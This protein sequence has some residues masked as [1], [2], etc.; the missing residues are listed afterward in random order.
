MKRSGFVPLLSMMAVTCSAGIG[1]TSGP[2]SPYPNS[3]VNYRKKDDC[4]WFKAEHL[5]L[6]DLDGET[7]DQEGQCHLLDNGIRDNGNKQTGI[8]EI[9]CGEGITIKGFTEKCAMTTRTSCSSECKEV[10]NKMNERKHCWSTVATLAVPKGFPFQWMCDWRTGAGMNEFTGLQCSP[11]TKSAGYMTSFGFKLKFDG[12]FKRAALA[13]AESLGGINV[14][15]VEVTKPKSK[16]KDERRLAVETYDVTISTKNPAEAKVLGGML[17]KPRFRQTMSTVLPNS[18]FTGI[19]VSDV[20]AAVVAPPMGGYVVPSFSAGDAVVRFHSWSPMQKGEKWDANPD[21][22]AGKKYLTNIAGISVMSMIIATLAMLIY[23]IFLCGHNLNCCK[24]CCG[25]CNQKGAWGGEKVARPLLAVMFLV[26]LIIMSTS[27]SG[28]THFKNGMA[29]VGDV[30]GKVADMFDN[31]EGGVNNIVKAGKIMTEVGAITGSESQMYTD[32]SGSGKGCSNLDAGEIFVDLAESVD[33]SGSSLEDILTDS[34]SDIRKMQKQITEDGPPLIDAVVMATVVLFVPWALFGLIGVGLGSKAP[35]MSDCFLNVVAALG[36]L[37]MWIVAILLAVELAV[38]VLLSDFCFEDPLVAMKSLV[39]QHMSGTQADMMNFYLDCADGKGNAYNTLLEPIDDAVMTAETL[40][41]LTEGVAGTS[42]SNVTM[43]KLYLPDTGALSLVD[44]A[45][46]S[47]K[48]TMACETINPLL[49][50][51]THDAIC[52]DVIGGLLALF[53]TQVV[54]A[55]FML[56]TLHFAS[57][58]RPYM[59][60][61]E[62]KPKGAGV[63]P[64][65]AD[66]KAEPAAGPPAPGDK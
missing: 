64:M 39:D 57:F 55:V 29:E 12:E 19:K 10:L 32:E 41:T 43:Q 7:K 9:A 25:C 26:T 13:I 42:C 58:V 45:I 38:G 47:V 62:K 16:A 34:G 27:T 44:G 52:T 22:D 48:T 2:V 17:E 15:D 65:A 54:A 33:D 46:A 14:A 1:D 28:A 66:D 56:F 40:R 21:S 11:N 6:T 50:S 31:L 20:T 59:N 23:W 51:V 37:L 3:V 24:R 4:A 60:K 35:R 30:F 61:K 53:N 63:A 8:I 5:A 18:P 49:V 36:L